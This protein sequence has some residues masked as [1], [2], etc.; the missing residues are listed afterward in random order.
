MSSASKPLYRL[1]GSVNNYPWGKSGSKSLVA[2]LAPNAIGSSFTT[3]ESEQYAELWLGTHPNGPSSLFAAE[4]TLQDV[5]TSYPTLLGS[6]AQKWPD[7]TQLPF[8]FKVLSIARALPL[9]AHPDRVR[10]RK[11]HAQ[12]PKSFVDANYK[13]EIAICIGRAGCVKYVPGLQGGAPDEVAFSGFVG[14]MPLSDIAAALHGTPEL[15]AAIADDARVDAFLEAP[16]EERLKDV[17]TQL[18]TRADV[19]AHV[20]AYV[21]RTKDR[22]ADGTREG[23]YA[24]LAAKVADQY[25]GDVGVFAT[26]FFMNYVQLRPGEGVYIADDEVHAYLEGDIIECMATSDNVLNAGLPAPDPAS[27][28]VRAFA[29]TLSYTSAPA[30]FYMLPALEH[31]K[32]TTAYRPPL[33]EF[34]VLHTALARAGDEERVCAQGAVVG[35]VLSGRVR[36]RAGGEELELEKGG[37]VFVGGREEV[38]V[39]ALDGE[40]EVWWAASFI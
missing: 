1:K 39:S 35:L 11:L 2:Q 33:Q 12:D 14:F 13:P 25:P 19:A 40:A 29:D 31:S 38:V 6:A 23:A 17:Y 5:L 16:S 20:R 27:S 32:H 21:S 37:A 10:A 30:P 28:E 4:T 3:E 9:Q 34:V 36:V 7:T 22:A 8:L 15:R 18:V 24:A 26:V